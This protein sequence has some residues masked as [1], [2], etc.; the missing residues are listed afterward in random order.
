MPPIAISMTSCTAR[1]SWP[2]AAPTAIAPTSALSSSASARSSGMS[3]PALTKSTT[4]P[5]SDTA[6]PS[7]PRAA[8][9][10][11]VRPA[12]RSRR[13]RF[14]RSLSAKAV[15]L[16]VI[17][18]AVPL[19][20]YDQFRAADDAAGALLLQQ[21]REEGRV[22][23]QA[24][25]PIL[26]ATEKPS[27]PD[28]GTQLQRFAGDLTRVKVIFRPTDQ[29][30][31]YYVAS[32]PTVSTAQLDNERAEL[33]QQG[34]L[35]K[36]SQTCEGELPFA[37]RYSTQGA[38]DE[39]VTSVTPI[40]VPSGCWAVVTS[41]AAGSYLGSHLGRPYWM[42]PEVRIAAIIYLVMAV[43]TLSTFWGVRRGLN[44]FA[45][46]A[47]AIRERRPGVSLDRK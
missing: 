45:E 39:V 34:V 26:G 27:I 43:V 22:M 35:D 14:H 28:L 41:F 44:R 18:L 36:L 38:E 2:A 30:A 12:A 46:R 24:L 31:F 1:I 9:P 13:W 20:I 6:G 25:L 8:T 19:I 15:L 42:A 37:F 40:K 5:D 10:A 11:V 47:R 17:F 7:P 23:A 33:A 32:W 4:M 3:T 21:V 29:T 16:V